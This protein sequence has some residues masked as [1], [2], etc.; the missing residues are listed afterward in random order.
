MA[1][2]SFL[3]RAEQELLEQGMHIKAGWIGFRLAIGLENASK[4]QLEEMEKAFYAGAYQL[5]TAFMAATADEYDE[6]HSIKLMR[7]V[8]DE[9]YAWQVGFAEKHGLPMPKK[10]DLR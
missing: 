10:M 7:K 9:L 2:K 5:F 3:R 6:D 1:D 8:H 4:T